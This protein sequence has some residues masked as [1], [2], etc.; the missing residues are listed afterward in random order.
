MHYYPYVD[1]RTIDAT[2]LLEEPLLRFGLSK[3]TWLAGVAAAQKMPMRISET[4]S[5]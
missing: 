1:N 4:G 3:F 2:G 5:L